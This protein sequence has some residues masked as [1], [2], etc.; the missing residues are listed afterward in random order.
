MSFLGADGEAE[1]GKEG[2]WVTGEILAD[3]I[4]AGKHRKKVKFVFDET[5]HMKDG[6]ETRAFLPQKKAS[7]SQN[8]TSCEKANGEC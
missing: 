4:S 1:S 3:M 2:V 7:G 6:W 5:V 8:D